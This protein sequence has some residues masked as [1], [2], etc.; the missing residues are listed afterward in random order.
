MTTTQAV[1]LG[2]RSGVGKSTVALAMHHL[3]SQREVRHAVIDGDNLDLAYPAPWEAHPG[4]LLAE[5]NLGSMWANYRDLGY[6]RV[7]YTNTVSV[8]NLPGLAAAIGGTVETTGILLQASS[9]VVRSRLAA[10]EQGSALDLHLSRSESAAARLDAEA[11]PHVYRVDAE[12]APAHDIAAR[13][14]ELTG[15]GDGIR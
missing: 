13:V 4:S 5:R 10:R 7:I 9:R 6:R 8:L 11:P 2:G 3:L 15:W 1:F 14:I 12:S